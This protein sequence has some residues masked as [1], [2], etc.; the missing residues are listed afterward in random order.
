MVHT[1]EVATP[2]PGTLAPTRRRRCS[3]LAAL[4]AS[5]LP[6][7][8]GRLP[9]SCAFGS[10]HW[11]QLLR[12]QPLIGPPGDGGNGILQSPTFR[13]ELVLHS[14][15]SV[16]DDDANHH[17]LGLELA[18]PFDEHPIAHVRNLCGDLVESVSSPQQ[19]VDDRARPTTTD[20]LD[21]VMVFRANCCGIRHG[22]KVGRAAKLTIGRYNTKLTY[23][24]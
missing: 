7:H 4:R 21:S 5:A 16:C 10:R 9:P 13:G 6:T 11:L 24:K 12:R 23:S 19:D 18:K 17:V 2:G 1:P 22:V 3:P 8:W 15:R 14:L 20:E